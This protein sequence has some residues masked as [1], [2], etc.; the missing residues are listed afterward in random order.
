[1]SEKQRDTGQLRRQQAWGRAFL[2][3]GRKHRDQLLL[4]VG[5]QLLAAAGEGKAMSEKEGVL[6]MQPSGRWAVCRPGR[7]PVE[8]TSGELFRVEVDGE[9]KLTRME[10]PIVPTRQGAWKAVYYSVDGYPLR[11]GLRAT[12]G[13]EG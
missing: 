1:M 8:I 2:K 11:N 6:K 7:E 4:Q 10:S 12:I 3:V 13:A 5:Q 9:L